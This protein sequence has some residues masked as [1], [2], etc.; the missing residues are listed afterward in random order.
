M[1]LGLQLLSLMRRV[2]RCWRVALQ[3]LGHGDAVSSMAGSVRELRM[4][5][6]RLQ[7]PTPAHRTQCCWC[8]SPKWPCTTIV[9]DSSAMYERVPAN[10]V[11]AA[12]CVV[13]R[14]LWDR[15]VRSMGVRHGRLQGRL[16]RQGGMFQSGWTACGLELMLDTLR[17]GLGV[18]LAR[19][20]DGIF[21]QSGGLPIGGPLSDLGAGLLLGLQE[22]TWRHLSPMR[23]QACFPQVGP[24]SCD[25]YV[26]HTRYVDDIVSVSTAFLLRLRDA[27]CREGAPRHPV[28]PG[29]GQRGRPGALARRGQSWTPPSPSLRRRP[30][31]A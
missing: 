7:Q 22:A 9:H 18:S 15:G 31:G 27:A 10:Q 28:Q 29:V 4:R 5:C 1:S 16:L 12:T 6:A 26:V 24:S 23:L 17:A 8:S 3:R 2:G 30:V 25:D 14:V 11:F 19:F 20:G 21:V 13:V